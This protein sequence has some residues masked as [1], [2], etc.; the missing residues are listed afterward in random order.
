MEHI[1]AVDPGT[2]FCGG[3]SVV[4]VGGTLDRADRG[5]NGDN[6]IARHWYH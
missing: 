1:E 2:G 3:G 6:H 4:R 5:E